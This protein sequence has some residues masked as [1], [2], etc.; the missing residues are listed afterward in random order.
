M[1]PCI[2]LL[3]Q[4]YNFFG[5]AVSTMKTTLERNYKIIQNL[6]VRPMAENVEYPT[7]FQ[8]LNATHDRWMDLKLSARSRKL[9][10]APT[11][12]IYRVFKTWY[13]FVTT[14]LRFVHG[15]RFDILVHIRTRLNEIRLN[16]TIKYPNLDTIN[17]R[18]SAIAARSFRIM[19]G[20]YY[21]VDPFISSLAHT[22]PKLWF[23]QLLFRA[24]RT[25]HFTSED[26]LFINILVELR[27]KKRNSIMFTEVM[28]PLNET[29]AIPF[30]SFETC[31]SQPMVKS[32]ILPY[33]R[34]DDYE[35]ND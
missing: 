21:D 14:D 35:Y 20:V 11:T 24:V 27:K 25:W 32:F 1:Q 18:F 9:T 12:Q 3:F 19:C 2:F 30:E 16:D 7:E 28:N 4:F 10:T 26:V 34:A 33:T 8:N 5:C 13:N 23:S 15:E 22:Y 17:K 31:I 29:V 6:P